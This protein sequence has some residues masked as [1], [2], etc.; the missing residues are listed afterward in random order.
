MKTLSL[1]ITLLI[2]VLVPKLVQAQFYIQ[3]VSGSPYVETKYKNFEGDP[4]LYNAWKIGD[5]KLK[6]GTVLNNLE[7]KYDLIKDELLFKAKDGQTML[8]TQ[9]V[10]EFTFKEPKQTFVNG[11]KFGDIVS[12]K[13]YLQQL[14]K[15]KI[16]LYKKISKSIIERSEYNA[17]AKI[18]TF[19]QNTKYFY[20]LNGTNYGL[21]KPN[22]KTLMAL[23]V[24]Q[25]QAIENFMLTHKLNL[26]KEEDLLLLIAY[27]HT[28]SAG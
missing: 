26:Q 17:A 21:L 2:S 5:I 25:Q 4:F 27:Y 8:F 15:G 20:A 11:I 14:S 24:D 19:V 6:D 18:E 23:L 28:L 3:D 13:T 9:P 16:T 10:I 7:L 22:K 1:F 12:E